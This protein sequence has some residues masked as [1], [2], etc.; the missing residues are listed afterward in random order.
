MEERCEMLTTA[1]TEFFAQS[2]R[3]LAACG[4]DDTELRRMKANTKQYLRYKTIKQKTLCNS[5][6]Y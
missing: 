5:V 4:N 1:G 6:L 2:L 3:S